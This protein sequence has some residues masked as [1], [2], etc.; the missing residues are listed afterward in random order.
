VRLEFE[1][2]RPL[3]AARGINEKEF[4]LKKLIILSLIAALGAATAATPDGCQLGNGSHDP[5]CTGGGS[6]VVTQQP[7]GCM[8]NNGGT[9]PCI[10]T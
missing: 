1:S 8:P 6:G 5:I 9:N 7:D 10:P 4:L 2:P 3:H